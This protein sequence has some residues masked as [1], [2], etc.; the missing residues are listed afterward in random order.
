MSFECNTKCCDGGDG[1]QEEDD[2]CIP[3]SLQASS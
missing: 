1:A 2:M 3:S